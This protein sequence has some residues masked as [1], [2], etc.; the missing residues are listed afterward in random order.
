MTHHLL[1]ESNQAPTTLQVGIS[2]GV[3]IQVEERIRRPPRDGVKRINQVART[4][5]F[6]SVVLP[7]GVHP[8][9]HFIHRITRLVVAPIPIHE[10][11]KAHG[12]G[13]EVVWNVAW[14]VRAVVS[15]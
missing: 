11:T 12:N 8:V 2:N 3:L 14:S 1:F 5:L 15:S 9:D 7:C 13:A 10:S 4:G 6:F